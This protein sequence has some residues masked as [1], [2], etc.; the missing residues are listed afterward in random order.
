MRVTIA[1]TFDA[2]PIREVIRFWQNRLSLSGDVLPVVQ[3]LDGNGL[4][5]GGRRDLSVVLIRFQDWSNRAASGRDQSRD[6]EA[7]IREFAAALRLDVSQAH[8]SGHHVVHLYSSLANSATQ[9]PERIGDSL[10]E[11]L[12][13]ELAGIPG[14]ELIAG[15]GQAGYSWEDESNPLL[16]AELGTLIAR[17]MYALAGRCRRVLVLECASR[18]PFGPG[19]AEELRRLIIGRREAG[20]I[21]TLKVD[22]ESPSSQIEALSREMG[23]PHSQFVFASG[24]S[25]SCVEVQSNCSEVVTICLPRINPAA[26]LQDTWPLDIAPPGQSPMSIASRKEGDW[27][28]L[29]ALTRDPNRLLEAIRE[30]HRKSRD[31]YFF[32]TPF[33]AARTP[34]EQ[35]LSDIWIDVLLIDRV[36]VHD[37]FFELDGDSLLAVTVGAR[38]RTSLGIQLT[39]RDL[40]DARTVGELAELVGRRRSS[41]P[42]EKILSALVE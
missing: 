24:D 22:G 25:D 20:A 19:P 21:G 40:F 26:V 3:S 15:V 5:A 39:M 18:V 13:S 30:G 33:V 36:G 6:V 9:A 29:S 28:A 38:I 12:R 16:F 2:E 23:Q 17:K 8:R 10:G 11:I 7:K 14:I 34:I 4:V 41:S 42:S 1:A 31:R 35:T 32:D 37:N 27:S